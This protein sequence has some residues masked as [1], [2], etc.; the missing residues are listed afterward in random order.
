MP[1]ISS[2]LNGSP[3]LVDGRTWIPAIPAAPAAG[4]GVGA[5]GATVGA[6]GAT[7]GADGATVG[8]AVATAAAVGATVG[9]EGVCVALACVVAVGRVPAHG[10]FGRFAMNSHGGRVEA[11][12]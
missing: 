2:G 11:A 8:V 10:A 4:V 1:S 3:V 7:V 9:V 6:D 12:V 5:D